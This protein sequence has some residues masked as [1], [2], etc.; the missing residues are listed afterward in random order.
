MSDIFAEVASI[1]YPVIDAD[2]HVNEPPETWVER[3]PSKLR[4][5]APRV[6]HTENGDWWLFDG[7]K[8]RRP[9]GLTATAGL[10]YLDFNSFGITYESMRPGSFDPKAR[11]VDMEIDGIYA[12]VLYPSVTLAGAKAYGDDPELQLACVR[13]YNDWLAEFCEGSD[14][15]LIGQSILPAT[16]VDDCIDEL[17]RGMDLGHRGAV[18]SS[19]PNGSFDPEP[20]DDRFWAVAQE[21]EYPI[22]VH[23]G[24]FLRDVPRPKNMSMQSL[25]FM[26][27]AGSSKSGAHTIPVTCDL[28]FSGAFEKFPRL[29]VLLVEANIGWIPTLLEQT[30]DMFLR[31]RWFTGGAEEMRTMPSRIFYRNFWATFMIDTVGIEL[32]HRMNIDH[33]MW[34]TD[35]P[36]TGTDWPNN[37][38]MIER[39]FRGVPKSEV[40]KMLHDNVK[41]LYKLDGIPDTLPSL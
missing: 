28:L 6:E 38:V 23:I 20:E 14:S 8:V 33:L 19:F 2:A 34:S 12:Q 32:R 26:G 22:A 39:N 9:V 1:D 17:K 21:A 27:M 35:Y 11:I 31:Y 13:A 30:D 24:S 16:G 10:S 25:R 40:K 4:E 41:R 37:R 15:R 5:R 3:V 18:I 7:G 36:H 29:R